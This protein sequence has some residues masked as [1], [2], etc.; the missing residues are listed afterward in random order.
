MKIFIDVGAHD[1]CSVRQFKDMTVDF[2]DYTIYCFE[3][4]PKLPRPLDLPENVTWKCLI[5]SAIDCTQPFYPPNTPDQYSGSSE[6]GRFTQDKAIW[7]Q[8]FKLSTFI[9]DLPKDAYL[10]VKICAGGS[11][12]CILSDMLVTGAINRVSRLFVNHFPEFLHEDVEQ[13][14]EVNSWNPIQYCTLIG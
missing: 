4:N 3:P 2:D 13:Y 10:V 12:E 7:V 5:A 9:L 8:G 6:K 14:L 1:G 11:E